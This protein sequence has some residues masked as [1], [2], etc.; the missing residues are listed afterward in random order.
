MWALGVILYQLTYGGVAPYSSVPG[1]KMGKLKAMLTPD[2]PVDFDPV[3]DQ[4]L[5]QTMKR[6]LEKNPQNRAGIAELLEHPFLRPRNMSVIL[7]ERDST[8]ASLPDDD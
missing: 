5:L 8:Q 2:Y 7:E 1:G 6:C 4:L 3:E